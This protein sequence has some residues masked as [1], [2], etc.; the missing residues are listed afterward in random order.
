MIFVDLSWARSYRAWA[1]KR[2][3]TEAQWEKAA[4][5]SH[6]TR[7]FPWGDEDADC[8]LA[9]VGQGG[10][11]N[12][13]VGDTTAVGSYP[14]GASPYGALDMAGNVFEWVADW[15]SATYYAV[16][17]AS[18]PCGPGAGSSRI[19]RGGS[20]WDSWLVARLAYRYEINPGSRAGS[21]GFRCAAKAP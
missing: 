14:G 12:R 13:C 3:P 2:L 9:N 8:S 19:M 20:W 18:N 21:I 7:K 6:D 17:P 10:F 5:G 15:Y 11:S 4:R 16:S 1:G